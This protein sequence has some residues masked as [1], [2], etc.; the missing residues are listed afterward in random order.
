ML[1]GKGAPHAIFLPRQKRQ[2]RGGFFSNVFLVGRE[3]RPIEGDG[4]DFKRNSVGGGVDGQGATGAVSYELGCEWLRCGESRSLRSD[5][6][7]R[8]KTPSWQLLENFNAGG[9]I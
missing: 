3:L 2:A 7:S 9:F 1:P 8:R 6:R 5:N 4:A